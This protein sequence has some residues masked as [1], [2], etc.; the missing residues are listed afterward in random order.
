MDCACMS[1]YY[2]TKRWF[3]VHFII[4]RI[5]TEEVLYSHYTRQN[6]VSIVL[7]GR[8]L[9]PGPLYPKSCA[10]PTK[11]MRQTNEIRNENPVPTTWD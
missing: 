6:T 1:L 4:N 10:L 9:N 3:T 11:L 7:T 2:S 8:G 5:M